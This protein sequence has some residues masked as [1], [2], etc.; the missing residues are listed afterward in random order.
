MLEYLIIKNFAIIDKLELNFGAGLNVFTG[1]TG[2]GKSIIVG[3]LNILLGGKISSGLIKKNALKASISASFILEN[4]NKCN[5]YV[6][7]NYACKHFLR[8]NSNYT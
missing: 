3:A 6:V 1:E 5:E 7:V 8:T 4:N 2:A